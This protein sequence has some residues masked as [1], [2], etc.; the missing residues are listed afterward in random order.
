MFVSTYDF[1]VCV[2]VL[3]CINLSFSCRNYFYDVNV[4]AEGVS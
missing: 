1:F 2:Y 3:I 4:I